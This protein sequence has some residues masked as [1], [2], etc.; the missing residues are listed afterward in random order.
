MAG[1]NFGFGYDNLGNRTTSSIDGTSSSYA[2]NSLNQYTSRTV[3]GQ[4]NVSGLAPAN[5]TVTVNGQ[6]ITRQA[7]YYFKAQ[8]VANASSPVWASSAIASRRR[9]SVSA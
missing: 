5:A 9:M 2:T 1:R 7:E 8:G 6:S 4:V 3:P